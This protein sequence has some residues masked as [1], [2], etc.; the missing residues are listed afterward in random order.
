MDISSI[1]KYV[2]ALLK[3]QSTFFNSRNNCDNKQANKEQK[4][5]VFHTSL[6]S[7]FAI[8]L[9]DYLLLVQ[10]VNLG[11]YTI[12]MIQSQMNWVDELNLNILMEH[13][14]ITAILMMYYAILNEFRPCSGCLIGRRYLQQIQLFLQQKFII[15]HL[16]QM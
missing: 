14:D 15:V 3:Y 9:W 10:S 8:L 1:K 7:P 2:F 13:I 4:C 16:I 11:V 12:M 5:Y 6:V